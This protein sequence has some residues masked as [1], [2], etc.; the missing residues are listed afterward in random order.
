MIAAASINMAIMISVSVTA[1]VF[2]NALNKLPSLPVILAFAK[3][4]YKAVADLIF[5]VFQ[6]R[7]CNAIKNRVKWLCLK[8]L[9]GLASDERSHARNNGVV[10]WT[11]LQ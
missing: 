5:R 8:E 1:L 4:K 10:C 3:R 2:G 7:S 11:E 6:I 9:P